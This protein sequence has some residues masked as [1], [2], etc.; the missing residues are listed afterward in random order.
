[1]GQREPNRAQMEQ[2]LLSVLPEAHRGPDEAILF[3]HSDDW[4]FLRHCGIAIDDDFLPVL[5]LWPETLA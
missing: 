1:M 2:W 5:K 4:N 3:T